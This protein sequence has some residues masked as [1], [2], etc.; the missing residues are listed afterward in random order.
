[1]RVRIVKRS[2]GVIDGIS[3][4]TFTPGYIYDLPRTI[5]E[6]LISL[7]AARELHADGPSPLYDDDSLVEHLSGGVKVT[8]TEPRTEAAD[9][10]PRRRPNRKR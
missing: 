9:R 8:A 10:A 6:D 2:S 4:G 7:G 3:L 1:M 5:G